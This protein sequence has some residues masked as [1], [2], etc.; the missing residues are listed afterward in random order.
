M[1]RNKDTARGEE[2]INNTYAIYSIHVR[3]IRIQSERVEEE[4]LVKYVLLSLFS[5]DLIRTI[6]I[7]RRGER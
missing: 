3:Q 4:N 5:F 2:I 6:Q 1:R 7:S